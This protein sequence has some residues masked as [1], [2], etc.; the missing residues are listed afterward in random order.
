M[1][2]ANS[3]SIWQQR[4]NGEGKGQTAYRLAFFHRMQQITTITISS[5]HATD[6]LQKAICS[7][8]R[9]SHQNSVDG[10]YV[11]IS[12]PITVG[13]YYETKH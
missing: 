8:S 9:G 6:M 11:G 4:G 1:A 2:V 7:G 12:T 10:G 13:K 3:W 5:I